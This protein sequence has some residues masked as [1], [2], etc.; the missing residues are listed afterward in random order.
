MRILTVVLTIFAVG[1]CD[2]DN[3][4][5][6]M[7]DLSMNPA[8]M[9]ATVDLAT[10][11]NRGPTD[12]HINF[13]PNG[14]WWDAPGKT[15]W[16]STSSG[17]IIK[18]TDDGGLSPFATVPFGFAPN[19]GDLGQLVKL[20]DG[21]ILVAVFGFGTTGGV[22]KVS[23]A[24]VSSQ[25]ANLNMTRRRIGLTVGSDGSTYDCWFIGM[26]TGTPKGGCSKLDLNGGGETDVLVG[27]K[28]PI[29]ILA[30]STD[31]FISDQ[32]GGT[33]YR[34]PLANMDSDGGTTAVLAALTNPDLLTFGPG[35]DIFSGGDGINRIKSDG[36]VTQF[37]P[38]MRHIKGVA[39]DPDNKRLFAG[40]PDAPFNADAGSTAILHILPVDN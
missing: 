36:T 23:P 25:I 18:W 10:G 9:S 7:P 40:E 17:Q 31:L 21:S 1:G 39:Y 14:L 2:D 29:G 34:M 16:I 19:S 22:V 24:G 20:S 5:M 32:K 15:L 38:E 6:M 28:T 35:N 12:I 13:E 11:I 27:L 8:D 33:L 3:G 26:S 37:A 30:G 4:M